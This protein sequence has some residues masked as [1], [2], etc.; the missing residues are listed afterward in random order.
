[1]LILST[2]HL[3]HISSLSAG[4]Y[5]FRADDHEQHA[6]KLGRPIH[7]SIYFRCSAVCV[8]VCVFV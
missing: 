3:Q 1:M 7:K 5:Q 4:S 2:A 8:Y 6:I